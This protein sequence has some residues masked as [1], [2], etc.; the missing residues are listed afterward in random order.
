MSDDL[1]P[2]SPREAV[3]LYISHRELEVSAKMLQNHKYRLN[4]FVE[5]CDEVRIDNLN[6]LTGR[7]LHRYRVW[8][9]QDVNI[10]TLR[11]QLATL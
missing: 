6:D 3:D 4:V 7:Y 8:R 9:Q 2:I 5:W 10:V 1:E 11:R